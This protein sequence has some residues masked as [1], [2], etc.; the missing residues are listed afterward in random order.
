[1]AVH[2]P[3]VVRS[4]IQATPGTIADARSAERPGT[5]TTTG[6]TAVALSAARSATKNTDSPTHQYQIPSA[7]AP[8]GSAER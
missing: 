7:K 2:V 4:R 6:T 1:M 8:A 3:G 5:K